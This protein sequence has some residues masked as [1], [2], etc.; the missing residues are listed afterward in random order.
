MTSTYA[1]DNVLGYSTGH[2]TFAFDGTNGVPQEGSQHPE[3]RA[4]HGV[5][6]V[7]HHALL[8]PCRPELHPG[9]GD[10]A[11]D[12]VLHR[13]LLLAPGARRHVRLLVARP[14]DSADRL[15]DGFSD[16]L[17]STVIRSYVV[18]LRVRRLTFEAGALFAGRM[19][20]TSV[21]IGGGVTFDGTENVTRSR[22]QPHDDVREP[23]QGGRP[24][25]HP[26]VR[27][28]RP[29]SQPAVP[30]LRQHEQRAR[31]RYRQGLR[32]R[33]RPLPGLGRLPGPATPARSVSRA[34]CKDLSDASQQT[35]RS[36]TRPRSPASSSRVAPTPSR[37]T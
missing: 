33:S 12:P 32:R 37:R 11:V 5:P 19:P 34:A 10:S 4:W 18:A 9:P 21:Y 1:V 3:P 8:P 6:D 30:G 14:R 24:L 15:L 28:D 22:Q 17:W 23:H 2:I 27:A 13:Q 25:R 7:E 29:G 36:S 16:D 20:M 31:D 35:S 26:G